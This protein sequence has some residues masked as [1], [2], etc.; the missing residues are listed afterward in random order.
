M[1]VCPH[2]VDKLCQFAPDKFERDVGT[3]SG[4]SRSAVVLFYVYGQG[5]CLIDV[6]LVHSISW[7]SAR[8]R[9]ESFQKS[10]PST[11]KAINF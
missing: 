6:C 4:K 1:A 11:K 5:A 8:D 9:Y 10:G 3:S 2:A 7:G